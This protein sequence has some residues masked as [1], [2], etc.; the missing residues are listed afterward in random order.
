MEICEWMMFTIQ[1]NVCK[2]WQHTNTRTFDKVRPE[3][4]PVKVQS[5]WYHI[6]IDLI[7]PLTVSE[8]GNH[9]ILTLSDYCTKWVEAVPLE[10]KLEL[11]S[12]CSRYVCTNWY[13]WSNVVQH[14]LDPSTLIFYGVD[15]HANG[16]STGTDLRSGNGIQQRAE[17]GLG[18]AHG[19]QAQAH[20][21]LPSPGICYKILLKC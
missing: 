21:C 8:N 14:H 3:L 16:N 12:H 11:L 9:Y 2:K 10:R 6:G 18:R 19:N 1:V 15:I 4:H 5:P 17:Q 13:S 20:H 7:G